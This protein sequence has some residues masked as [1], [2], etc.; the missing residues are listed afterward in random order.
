MVCQ[1]VMSSVRI[2][3]AKGKEMRVLGVIFFCV[4]SG[5]S[6]VWWKELGF[7][8]QADPGLESHFSS[9]LV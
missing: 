4:T 6:E 3:W 9:Y 5:G 7:G 2:S 8:N 1:L